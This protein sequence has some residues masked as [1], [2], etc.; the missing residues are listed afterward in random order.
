MKVLITGGCGFV[1]HHFVEHFIKNTAW[2]IVIIDRLSYSGSLDRLRD[3]NV[4]D[5]KR[6]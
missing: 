6:V 1:G 3:I 4:F 2:D 5:D